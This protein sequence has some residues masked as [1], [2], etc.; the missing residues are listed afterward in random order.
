MMPFLAEEM[1]Q[2]LVRSNGRNADAPE[3]VHHTGYPEVDEALVDRQLLADVALT[4]RLVSLGRAA[5]N[6][7]A[8]KVRQP[9][10][11]MLVRL[12]GR[13]DEDSLARMVDQVL[14]ELNVKRLT[15]TNQVGDMIMYSIKPN[16][17]VMGPKY[18]KR[19]AGIREALSKLEPAQ[20][21]AQVEV[22][23]TVDVTVD[24][25]SV[26]LQAD[27]LLVETRERE[28]FAVAQEAG[29]VVALDTELDEALLQE[30]LAR[31]LVRVI[32]DMRKSANFSVSDRISTYYALD[33]AE[34]DDRALMT[35]ALKAFGDYI[36][37]ETL[38]SELVEGD[39][40][41]D[42]FTQ[43]EQLGGVL[44]RLAVKR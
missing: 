10:R 27:E 38:S 2:N 34:A 29:L 26:E 6:K 11:E 28:G 42:A 33:G 12:P 3:S 21:A 20:V 39:P 41:E 14:E 24:G 1:Y 18:G 44:L 8:V 19:M 25:E 40:P 32:N 23:Q 36:K 35:E 9:L 13:G 5:R 4:Q 22:G 37:S 7:A 43:E 17:P 16:F 30:G 31:D 15:V